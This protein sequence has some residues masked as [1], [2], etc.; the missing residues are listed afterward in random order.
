M[1]GRGV[2]A[3]LDPEAVEDGLVSEANA[4]AQM[5]RRIAAVTRT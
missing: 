1:S 4:T 3:I 2:F 5:V